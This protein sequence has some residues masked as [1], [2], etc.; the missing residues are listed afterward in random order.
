MFNNII[1]RAVHKIVNISHN[2]VIEDITDFVALCD[3]KL[4]YR[5]RR[6]KFMK[7]TYSLMHPVLQTF[8][9]TFECIPH[10]KCFLNILPCTYVCAAM[11]QNK[12]I[13]KAPQYLKDCCIPL[14]LVP[15][16]T[17]MNNN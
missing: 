6:E 14:S 11:W 7:K 1:N 3:I 4:R 16:V 8:V 17:P 5:Q 13:H 10:D 15:C 12:D 2:C 9:A